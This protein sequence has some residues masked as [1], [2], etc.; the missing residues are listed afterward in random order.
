MNAKANVKD[1]LNKILTVVLVI[2]LI[3]VAAL[4]FVMIASSQNDGVADIFG[5]SPIVIYDTKSMEPDITASDLVIV[6]AQ[7][8]TALKEGDIISFWA[9]V[10]GQKTIITHEIVEV[11]N[12]GTDTVSYQT[13]GKN[14]ETNPLRDQDPQNATQ[15]PNIH[16]EDIIG[17]YATK[18]PGLG[19][20]MNFLKTPMGILICLVIPI[21]LIFL[22][23]LYRVIALA[24]AVHREEQ[25]K[26]N[27]EMSEDE[28]QRVI[29]EYLRKQ[30]EENATKSSE[31]SEATDNIA[32][33]E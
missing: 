15:Q 16:P 27:A 12:G 11:V 7:D 23:Q 29:E 26:K 1:V 10:D 33:E 14:R 22:W 4:S 21:A 3:L 2:V 20:V 5:Y 30:Q 25:A 17:V 13:Q 28:K 8:H 9:F 6:K 24:M 18:I 31:E 19:A 32:S